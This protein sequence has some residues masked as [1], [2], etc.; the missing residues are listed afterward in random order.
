V[1]PATSHV[2]IVDMA[3]GLILLHLATLHDAFHCGFSSVDGAE[4]S[5]CRYRLLSCVL[6]SGLGCDALAAIAHK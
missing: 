5:C 3:V 6:C 4:G 2:H 1:T